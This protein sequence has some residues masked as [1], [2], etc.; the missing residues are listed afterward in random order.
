[1]TNSAYVIIAANL[2]P[3]GMTMGGFWALNEILPLYWCESAIIGFFTLLKILSAGGAIAKLGGRRG[4]PAEYTQPDAIPGGAYSVLAIGA[5]IFMAAFFTFHFG[6]FMFV[7]GI[8]LFGFVLQ[9]MHLG[10]ATVDPMNPYLWLH[11]LWSVKW[12]IMS[13]FVGHAASFFMNYL[14]AGEYR[15]ARPDQCMSAPYPRVIVMHLTILLG[16]FVSTAMPAA[17]PVLVFFVAAKIFADVHAH[18]KERSKAAEQAPASPVSAPV[19]PI[20]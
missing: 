14:G 5:K 18:L 9:G 15:T 1:M 7:H 20:N 8:F 2:L 17:G 11:Y 10:K 19:P 12:G 13:L 6:L 3:L 16:A 4:A